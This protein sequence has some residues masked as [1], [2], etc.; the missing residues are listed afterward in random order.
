MR[1]SL[2]YRPIESSGV[3]DVVPLSHENKLS[4]IRVICLQ[5][6]KEELLDAYTYIHIYSAKGISVCAPEVVQL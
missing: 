2:L 1:L 3:K 4:D 5:S 6:T